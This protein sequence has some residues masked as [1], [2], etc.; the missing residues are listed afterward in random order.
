MRK[1]LFVPVDERNPKESFSIRRAAHTGAGVRLEERPVRRAENELA[2]LG[3][4]LVLDPVH[5][6]GDMAASIDEGLQIASPAD[7]E[8]RVSFVAVDESERLRFA[9]RKFVAFEN[10]ESLFWEGGHVRSLRMRWRFREGEQPGRDV[11]AVSGAE[12][13]SAIGGH[14]TG[15]LIGASM[16]VCDKLLDGVGLTGLD[17]RS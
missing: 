7:D 12:V 11:G 14:P 8:A 17:Q 5:G 15:V 2:I 13:D 3:E 10:E 16:S 4:E 6:H 1:N 9:I